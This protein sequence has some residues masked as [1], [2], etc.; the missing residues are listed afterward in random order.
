[1]NSRTAVQ[2]SQFELEALEPRIMLSGD[3]A[4]APAPVASV[5]VT[6]D[7]Q[8]FTENANGLKFQSSSNDMFEGMD[9]NNKEPASEASQSSDSG[10]SDS[11]VE[12]APRV[13]SQGKVT[14][15]GDLNDSGETLVVGPGEIL[16]GS[17]FIS[18]NVDVQ[19]TFA[20]GNSPGTVTIDGDLTL[21]SGNDDSIEPDD[22]LMYLLNCTRGNYKVKSGCKNKL[23]RE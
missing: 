7:G 19:G 1:M 11:S 10:E 5:M 12:T 8:G 9:V 6:V 4:P 21:D 3:G 22:L 18:G 20:S 17:G 23:Q 13:L 16:K 14:L 2:Q 15:V